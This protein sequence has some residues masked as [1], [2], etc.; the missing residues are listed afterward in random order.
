[1]ILTVL[2]ALAAPA[3]AP[4]TAAMDRAR[5]AYRSCLTTAA[6][7][8]K[9]PAVTADKFAEFVK[10]QC[11]AQQAALSDAMISFD[12]HNGV[13]RKNAA[14]GAT[15]AVDDMLETAKNGWLARQN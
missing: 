13:S 11:A 4:N 15:M 9:P 7:G 1:M 8:A 5:V 6:N 14:D 12:M 3:A 10:A 2:M